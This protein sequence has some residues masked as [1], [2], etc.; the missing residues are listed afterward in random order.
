[1]K[2]KELATMPQLK[3]LMTRDV[4]AR[5]I[6]RAIGRPADILVD[7]TRHRVSLIVMS[8]GAIPELSVVIP[9]EAVAS[10]DVDALS[11]ESLAA[12]HLAV[13]DQALLKE[14]EGG[15]KLRRRSVFTAQGRRLGRIDGIE[16][17]GQG[18]VVL[19][20]V[21]K[22]RLG[23]LRP[24]LKLRP[25]EVSGLGAEFAVATP[26]PKSTDEAES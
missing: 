23:L 8:D 26:E 7:A 5:D 19:Y 6:G 4:Q 18:Q 21:R 9:A 10:F 24:R 12:V 25:S 1:M 14:L 2:F 22:P 13:H 16:I 20:R 11:I 3:N 15:L 17:D